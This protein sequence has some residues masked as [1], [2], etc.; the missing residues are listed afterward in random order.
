MAEFTYNN[1]K[2]VNTSYIFFEINCGYHPYVSLEYKVDFYLKFSLG[3][4]LIKALR[5]LLSNCR[6]NLL[7]AEKLQK[8]VHDKGVKPC[9][10]ALGKKIW[11]DS[12]YIKIKQN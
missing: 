6:K 11:L 3:D 8:R 5:E 1:A 12:K 2:N 4:K 7:H 9:S 10:Y